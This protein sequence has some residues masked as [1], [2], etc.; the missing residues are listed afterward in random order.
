MSVWLTRK[1]EERS[2]LARVGELGKRAEYLAFSLGREMYGLPIGAIVEILRPLPIAEVPR[3]SAE[4]VGVMSV[5]GRLV[6]VIDIKKML[7]CAHTGALERKAR[8]LLVDVGD[9]LLGLLVDQVHQVYRL[10]ADQVESS[11][12]FGPEQSPHLLGIGRPAEGVVLLLLDLRPL[13]GAH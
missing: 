10:A 6:T 9:E 11:D 12:A 5:R 4:I 1:P 8:V 2:A 7:H 13:F 3:A